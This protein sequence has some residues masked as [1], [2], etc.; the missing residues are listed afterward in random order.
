MHTR[1]HGCML[2]GARTNTRTHGRTHG[3]VSNDMAIAQQEIFGPVLSM[4]PCDD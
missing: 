4:I 3:Q 1:T 2:A